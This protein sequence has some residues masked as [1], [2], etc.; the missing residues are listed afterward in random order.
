MLAAAIVVTGIVTQNQ[1]SLRAAPRES[2]PQQAV[3]WAGDVLEVRG[4]R[5]GYLQ[6][7]D[8]RRER[9]G[10]VRVSQAR[11][12]PLSAHE[13]P[14]LLAVVRFLRDT[15]G[16]ETLGISYAAAYLKAVPA[17][18][19]TAEP[20]DAIGTMADRL[21]HRASVSQ[22]RVA[23]STIAAHLEVA[24]GF[25]LGM[26]NF[27]REGSTQICYEGE[28][29][30]QVL[31][32]PS[33]V[34]SERARA[35]LALTRPEC[36][37]PALGPTAIY[38]LQLRYAEMLDAVPT[39]DLSPTLL[40]QLHLRRAGLSAS[41]A[42]SAVR[43]GQSAQAVGQRAVEE[44]TRVNVAELADED[45]LDYAV[46]ALRVGA[47]RWAAESDSSTPGALAVR[48]ES[49]AAGETCVMLID[50]RKP[51]AAPL[52]RRCTY[53]TVWT[54][55]ARSDAT[56]HALTLAVQPLEGWREMWV[57]R[58]VGGEW[59][60][61][62]LVPGA[63]KPELGYIEFAGW[64]PGGQSLLVAREYIHAGQHRRRFELLRLS[65]LVSERTASEPDALPALRRWQDPSWTR[66]TVALR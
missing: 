31:A 9:A 65:T 57:F 3:L 35:A 49:G 12:H 30:R 29:F 53:G 33:A 1:V 16:S 45:Q 11:R 7:Y 61:D 10:Y 14:E 20:F 15:P 2:A 18:A 34:A 62:V 43:R 39:M 28:M 40:N 60:S 36:V 23:E 26:R 25:G 32:M 64:V 59:S 63:E 44:L 5:R 4:E 8:H 55:S 24:A 56:G 42:F 54:A 46:A 48:T 22:S 19:L 47:S 17:G 37:D 50:S 41:I 13:A 27:E 52:A 6:V 58:Q 38:A 51:A 21:A 66:M